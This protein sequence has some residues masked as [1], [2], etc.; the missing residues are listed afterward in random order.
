MA[1]RLLWVR[2][3]KDPCP[4]PKAPFAPEQSDLS[5]WGVGVAHPS[6]TVMGQ[7]DLAPI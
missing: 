7:G 6:E 3:H 4:A 2:G 1:P 5:L